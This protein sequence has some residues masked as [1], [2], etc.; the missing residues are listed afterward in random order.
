[1]LNLLMKKPRLQLT[2]I[3]E[4]LT[5]R[6]KL[7]FYILSAITEIQMWRHMQWV[8]KNKKTKHVSRWTKSNIRLVKK[9]SNSQ[10]D[11]NYF[12]SA[13]YKNQIAAF[14][15]YFA[16]WIKEMENNKP[17]FSP[18]DEITWDNALK[19]VRGKSV[20]GNS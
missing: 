11:E 15:N 12:D 17:A 7:M 4:Q 19:L 1:M 10:L 3:T 20:K 16:E 2:I 5:T 9:S 13:E 8:A 14:N 18:F 6:K